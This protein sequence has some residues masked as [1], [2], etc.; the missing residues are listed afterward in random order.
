MQES[1]RW[2]IL[3][4]KVRP[5][6]ALK[7]INSNKEYDEPTEMK[8]DLIKVGIPKNK[9]YCDYAGFSTYDS[10]VRM[11]KVFQQ[12]EIIIAVFIIIKLQTMNYI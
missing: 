1:A 9:I 2:G 3:L 5:F 4:K 6:S 8:N 7:G 11:K 10:I 12:K